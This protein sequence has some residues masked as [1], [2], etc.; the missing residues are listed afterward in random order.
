[1]AL[2]QKLKSDNRAVRIA[3]IR[4]LGTL[5]AAEALPF[6]VELLEDDDQEIRDASQA[7]LEK[8]NAE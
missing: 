5:K 3:A 6:L 8:I 4:S 2:I 7:A 1:M